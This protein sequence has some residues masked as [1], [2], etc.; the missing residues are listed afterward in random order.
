M[1]RHS[2][3]AAAFLTLVITGC[4]SGDAPTAT[5]PSAAP[6]TPPVA[7]TSKPPAA[8]LAFKNPIVPA[9]A[10]QAIPIAGLIQPTNS[11]EREIIIAKGRP[12]PFGQLFGKQID[13]ASVAK[14]KVKTVPKLPPLPVAIAKTAPIKAPSKFARITEKPK[15]PSLV[16]V[17]PKVLPPVI[18]SSKL[19][20]ILPPPPEPESAK[21]VTV[22]GV[23]L[24]GREPQAIIKVPN[25]PSSRYVQV[26]QRLV[27]GVL[28]KRIEMNQG[29]N[30]LVILE[31]YGIEVAKAVGEKPI[32]NSKQSTTST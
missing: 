27:N 12:D 6:S 17:L 26:G 29:S 20:S 24:V 13:T 9:P 4:S 23:L 8:A 1:D 10:T 22:T 21:L 5:N 16:P 31:Q 18:P 32:T 25:E 30:P 2:Q 15:P 14:T 11:Q 3:I 19:A 28:V 7:D